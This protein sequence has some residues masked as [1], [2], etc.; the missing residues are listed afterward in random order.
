MMGPDEV[1]QAGE[2]AGFQVIDEVEI[3]TLEDVKEIPRLIPPAKNVKLY[4]GEVK[5]NTNKDNTYRSLNIRFII[6]DGIDVGGELK[7]K[8]M[9]VFSRLCYYADPEVYTKDF[10][11]NRQH[12]VE[13]KNLIAATQLTDS[14]KINDTFCTELK[15]QTILGNLIQR[16]AKAY[17]DKE[18]NEQPGEPSNEVVNL[19]K[20]SDEDL[21]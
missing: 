20:V 1:V 4:I 13:L 7:Y 21:V 11:K 3:G 8:G 12:L 5:V 17:T 16:K 14:T 6:S 18:G 2:D 9:G 19:K 10:F 15:G